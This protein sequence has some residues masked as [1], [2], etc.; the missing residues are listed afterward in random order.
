MEKRPSV[1]ILSSFPNRQQRLTQV[2]QGKYNIT[3]AAT[4]H[5]AR[6]ALASHWDLVLIGIDDPLL[7]RPGHP[8]ELFP[9]SAVVAVTDAPVEQRLETAF[10]LGIVDSICLPCPDTIIR[11]RVANALLLQKTA[12]LP[13]HWEEKLYRDSVTKLLNRRYYDDNLADAE[14]DAVAFLDFDNFKQI[15]D[16]A[17]HLAGDQT[18]HLV[19]QAIRSCI[20]KEDAVIRYGGDEFLIIFRSIPQQ[21]FAEKLRFIHRKIQTTQIPA[22]PNLQFSVS[23]GG[24]YGRDTISD[25]VAK[26]DHLLYQAKDTKNT[27]V[28]A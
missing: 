26:A 22:H 15:N 1:L 14:A 20:R 21:A 6:D 25:M 24:I 2:L 23:I 11:H 10:Q 3:I 5:Q 12:Q 13:D 4:R 28:I 27:V 8:G 16:T 9:H 18:L 17:G 19:A 7:D